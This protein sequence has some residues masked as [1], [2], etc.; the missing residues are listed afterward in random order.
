[1]GPAGKIRLDR[2]AAARRCAAMALV[3]LAWILP[4]CPGRQKPPP[5]VI[6]PVPMPVIEDELLS[7]AENNYK[8]EGPVMNIWISLEAAEKVLEKQPQSER[9]NY[10]AARAISWLIQFG[11]DGVDVKSLAKLGYEYAREAGKLD[12]ENGE[13]A[14]LEGSL[15]GFL[16]QKSPATHIGSIKTI[17][18]YFDCAMNLDP[19]FD[20]GAPLRAMG[21]LL[22]K[23]PAWPIGVGD[24]DEGI[25]VMNQAVK[26]HPDHPA[27]HLYLAEA[28]V[29]TERY[30]EA[31]A[32]V[33][34]AQELLGSGTWGVP[35]KIWEKKLE[36]MR[37]KIAEK[38]SE[39]D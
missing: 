27:N 8:F 3:A 36:E 19:D 9:A 32:S 24:P 17:Y 34:K 31:A 10:Y 14:F 28:L 38:S 26:A 11:G 30:E 29:L 6:P 33:A 16:A 23:S 7:M 22:V 25:K 20:G 2:G 39:E 21:M 18:E 13:Y 4:G 15:L 35:G 1:M 37:Q 5:R 12:S